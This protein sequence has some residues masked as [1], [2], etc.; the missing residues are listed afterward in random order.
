MGGHFWPVKESFSKPYF[1]KI[2][3]VA[4]VFHTMVSERV[5][6]KAI[7]LYQVLQEIYQQAFGLFDPVIVQ[8]FIT[9]LMNRMIG[10][11]VLL[12]D[13]RVARIVMIN[14][15]DLINP[16]VESEGQYYDL[17]WSKNRIMDFVPVTKNNTGL[18]YFDKSI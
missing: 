7:P 2:V 12:S 15:D 17:R 18:V 5:Y 1:S 8:C 3:A 10:D 16:L 14:P 11:S 4:D 9:N 6:K 13:G